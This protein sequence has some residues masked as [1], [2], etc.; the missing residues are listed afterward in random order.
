MRDRTDPAPWIALADARHASSISRKTR[1]VGS[2]DGQGSLPSQHGGIE[3]Q[4]YGAAEACEAAR[5]HQARVA[6]RTA[7]ESD[8]ALSFRRNMARPLTT[9]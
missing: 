1:P 6:T 3:H 4:H 9:M 2:I 7:S 8:V 5:S